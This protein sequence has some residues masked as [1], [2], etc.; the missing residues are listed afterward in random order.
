MTNLMTIK[1]FSKILMAFVLATVSV[2]SQAKKE[3]ITFIHTDHLG[4]PIMA[5]NEDGSVKWREDYQPFGKQLTN[6]D[7]DNNIGF[8][9]HLDDKNLGLSYMQ[10]RW[11]NP[12]VG[13]FMSPDPV[14]YAEEN[15]IMSFNRYLY[16]NNNPY[17]YKDPD[18]EFLWHAVGAAIGAGM[19]IGA[20]LY[21]NGGDWGKVD[22]SQ[23]LVAGAAGAIGVGLG[24][25]IA[26]TVAEAGLT[27]AAALGANIAG[28]GAAGA[29]IGGA[30]TFVNAN[31][32]NLQG[33][34]V[35]TTWGDAGNSALLGGLTGGIGAGL[36]SAATKI[37]SD[38]QGAV[39]GKAGELNGVGRAFVEG[40]ADVAGNS[41]DVINAASKDRKK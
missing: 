40:V 8:T 35:N 23:V 31:V 1:Q 30:S 18:G 5:T 2:V 20:Q 13:R 24:G 34:E 29:L 11:Y 36:G 26:G 10:A 32:D 7:T 28:N 9:G 41:S 33:Q 17:K 6:Q 19:N 27:G 14:M 37:A 12:T 16:V 39:L 21:S 38:V 22:V 15:P 25:A 3:T 4:S